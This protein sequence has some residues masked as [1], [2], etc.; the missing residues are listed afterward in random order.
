MER[1][2]LIFYLSTF[3]LSPV[4]FSEIQK[5]VSP[6]VLCVI[7]HPD[8]EVSF[9]ATVYKIT[10][11]LKGIVDILIITNGEAGYKYSTLGEPIYCLKLTDEKIGRRNLPI[12]RKR[13]TLNAGKILGVHN[14]FF[15]DQRDSRFT[16]DVHEV[17]HGIWNI[18]LIKETLSKHLNE[19]DYDFVFTLLPHEGTH[20]HHKA[21]TVLALEAIGERKLTKRPIILAVDT[22]N[23]L[24]PKSFSELPGF[25]LTKMKE[26]KPSFSF[27]KL[28]ALGYQGKLNYQII[29]N[30]TI[31]EHKSQGMLQLLVNK[32]EAENFYY[33]DINGEERFIFT[34]MF[35]DTLNKE[36]FENRNCFKKIIPDFL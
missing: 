33:F 18:P 13:E 4:L 25:P 12:I 31:A 16:L 22:P 17:F 26:E 28:Q 11:D 10:H 23:N 19:G 32:G 21:A 5:N 36:S 14:Y 1:F 7:A 3:F 8:D 30:W 34:K 35:F 24:P 20:G 6:N 27:N 9:A 2:F 15:L 29:V